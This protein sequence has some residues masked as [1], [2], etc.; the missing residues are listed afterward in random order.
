MNLPVTSLCSE[1]EGSGIDKSHDLGIKAFTES[2]FFSAAV[3]QF[4]FWCFDFAS[5]IE[6]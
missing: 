5:L 4:I 3:F 2:R 6:I 1:A